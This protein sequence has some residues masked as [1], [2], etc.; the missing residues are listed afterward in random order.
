MIFG[1]PNPLLYGII[2]SFFSL[3]PIIGTGVVWLP[4]GLY[5]WLGEGNI[6]QSIVFMSLALFSYLSLENFVKPSILDKKLKLH[7]FVLF[8]SLLGGIQEFGIVGL[9]IGPVAVTTIVIL[10]DFWIDYRKIHKDES[11]EERREII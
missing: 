5:M 2:G 3:I 4:A 7:P 1:I 10:W 6:V 8:L 9:V 11:L